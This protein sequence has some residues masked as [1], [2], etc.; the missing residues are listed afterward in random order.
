MVHTSGIGIPILYLHRNHGM[1]MIY[2]DIGNKCLFGGQ[3]YICI[4]HSLFLFAVAK[5]LPMSPIPWTISIDSSSTW[6]LP[7][8]TK[9]LPIELS[10]ARC[11][12]F[13]ASNARVSCVCAVFAAVKTALDNW[14]NHLSCPVSLR[15]NRPSVEP[16][17]PTCMLFV[18]M[19]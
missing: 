2:I 15:D 6:L 13:T 8:P 12:C 3:Q 5:Q 7:I 9:I 18:C 10:A 11:D 17:A 16:H 4:Q 19:W 1:S 14:G